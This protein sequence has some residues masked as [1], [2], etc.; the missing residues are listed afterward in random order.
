MPI[1]IPQLTLS[2]LDPTAQKLTDLETR[3]AK[4]ESVLSVGPY[5]E[6]TLKSATAV[7]IEAG[8]NLTFKGG[9]VVKMESGATMS[10][11]SSAAFEMR[12]SA[13]MTLTGALI[14]IN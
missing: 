7:S 1:A 11:K 2:P 14:N 5:G 9:I 3:L 8:T 13:T 6:A 12:A 10:L 4:L